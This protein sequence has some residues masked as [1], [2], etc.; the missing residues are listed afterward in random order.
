MEKKYTPAPWFVGSKLNSGTIIVTALHADHWPALVPEFNE[1]AREPEQQANARLIA[2]A[3]AL[4]EALEECVGLLQALVD[5]WAS[6]QA[7]IARAQAAIATATDAEAS[8]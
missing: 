1:L 2:S 4:L 3:P 6:M 5:P 8:Q 7:T